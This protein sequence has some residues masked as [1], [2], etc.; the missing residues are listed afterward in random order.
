M[1]ARFCVKSGDEFKGYSFHPMNVR[2][3]LRVYGAFNRLEING[4]GG[5]ATATFFKDEEG[6]LFSSN[7]LKCE[8]THYQTVLDDSSSN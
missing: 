4:T 8:P 5:F 2:C 3:M 6:T 1:N 7:Q